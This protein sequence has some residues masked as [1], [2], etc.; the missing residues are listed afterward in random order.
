[1]RTDDIPIYD[2]DQAEVPED[3]YGPPVRSLSTP[4]ELGDLGL[5]GVHL[6]VVGPQPEES[7]CHFP[8][9]GSQPQ[10]ASQTGPDLVIF[11]EEE[12]R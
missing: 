1:M 12:P 5:F 11:P 2:V 6:A 10:G 7:E 9:A 4:G 3:P 8:L